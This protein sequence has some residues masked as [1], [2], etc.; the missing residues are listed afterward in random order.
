VKAAIYAR[1]S[2]DDN[3]RNPENKSV[4]R[5]VEHSR[6]YA[7]RK[8]WTVDDDCV[9]VDDGL[10]GAEFAKRQGLLRMLTRLRDFD[11]IIMSELSRIG[12]EQLQTSKVLSDIYSKGVKVYFYL[13]DEELE[14]ESAVDK[15]MC[16]AVAFAAEV[17]REKASQRSRDA[18]ERKARH[19]YNTGGI[20]Y[21]YDNIVVHCAALNGEQVKSHTDYRIN[22]EQADVV[23]RIFRM[24]CD[25]FGPTSIAKTLNGDPRYRE[26]GLRYFEGM[27]PR[28]PRKGT[29]SWAPSSIREMLRNLRYTGKVPFGEFRKT[30]RAGSKTRV[31]TGDPTYAGRP[32]L[33]IISDTLWMDAERRIK[34]MR[35]VYTRTTGG[36][37]WG[38]PPRGAASPYLLSGLARC[39]CCGASIVGTRLPMGS[40]RGRRMV[41]FYGC[42]WSSR[43][44]RA[45]CANNHRVRADDL[46]SAVLSAI[47]RT[48][49]SP[50]AIEYVLNRAMSIVVEQTKQAPQVTKKL[51]AELRKLSRERDSLVSAI[52]Y[53]QP[54]AA[55]LVEITRREQRISELEAALAKVQESRGITPQDLTRIRMAMDA[56]MRDFQ[57][58]MRA[59]IPKARDALRKLLN[60]PIRVTPVVHDARKTFHVAGET[61]IGALLAS[62]AVAS[63][64]GFEPRLPP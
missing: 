17:E 10:S 11:C 15:F 31:R 21:G 57:G 53:G 30:Y 14:F 50:E 27:N 16:S 51:T 47:E 37:L 45:V 46:D 58:L 1:K 43:R 12:R 36:A 6:A 19:G 52:A 8:G 26:H 28:T 34:A 13:T 49:L 55:L 48:V 35:G 62:A 4:Q 18:L 39:H 40:R 60:G 56:R 38:R 20:V 23:R 42:S 54:P 29:G 61:T 59:D 2:N 22:D 63:P 5:Q 3:D 32:D 7:D 25:G 64:R 24:Y 44:G 9:F 41:R 33:R